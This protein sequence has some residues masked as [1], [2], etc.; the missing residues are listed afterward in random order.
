MSYGTQYI[1]CL[2]YVFS[3]KAHVDH[4]LDMLTEVNSTFLILH[5]IMLILLSRGATSA[6]ALN[7]SIAEAVSLGLG[8]CL[9]D[10]T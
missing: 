5:L 1:R 10:D 2:V 9:M 6:W 3:R 4:V 8:V 7:R